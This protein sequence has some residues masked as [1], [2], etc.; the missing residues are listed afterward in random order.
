MEQV[1]W[2]RR[3]SEETARASIATNVEAQCIHSEL[4]ERYSAKAAEVAEKRKPSNGSGK[5]DGY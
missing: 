3:E 2:L 5:Q 1:Y 4:A